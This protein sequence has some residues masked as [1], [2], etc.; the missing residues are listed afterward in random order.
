LVLLG[1]DLV[2]N[3][4][5]LVIHH[6]YTFVQEKVKESKKKLFFFSHS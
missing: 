1:Q 4:I 6:Q 5:E 2:L 3:E